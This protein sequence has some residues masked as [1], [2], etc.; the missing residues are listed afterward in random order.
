MA[1]QSKKKIMIAAIA[2]SMAAAL[3]IGGGSFAFLK[4]NAET[5]TNNFKTN[6]VD[7]DLD[8]D[9]GEEQNYQYEIIPGT[10][11]EKDPLAT[12]DNTVDAYLFVTVTDKTEDLVTYTIADGWT[13]L[14]GHDGVYYREVA[15]DATDKEFPI[16]KDNKVSY[17]TTI[18]NDDMEGKENLKLSFDVFGIQKAGFADAAAAYAQAPVK[19]GTGAEITAAITN[20][21]TNPVTIQLPDDVKDANGSKTSNG[22]KV[23]I[24]LNNKTMSIG[25]PVGSTN[26]VTNGAQLLKGSTVTIKN[27]TYGVDATGNN[28]VKFLIQNY[29]DLT[30]EDVTLDGVTN[31]NLV[32]TVLSSNYGTTIIKGNT[33][34]TA[35]AGAT[36]IDVMDWVNS[37]YKDEGVVC[38]IDESMTGTVDGKIEVYQYDEPAGKII[39]YATDVFAGTKTYSYA[40][41]KPELIIKGGTFK[42]TGLTLD[43]FKNF[44]ADGYKATEESAGVY[45][46]TKA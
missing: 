27:G 11:Q 23:T 4:D 24:D 20:A 34:I 46:V 25:T 22:Q 41:T 3:I 19:A 30:L 32:G 45:V 40:A 28:K 38:I 13:P 9:K 16:L 43:Q 31:A 21:G 12:I 44:V 36:A 33:N 26:T 15:A 35:K 1:M 10:E 2:G 5:I 17:E 42:N 39:T 14:A 7:V 18:E 6:K 29:S 37:A 8:E